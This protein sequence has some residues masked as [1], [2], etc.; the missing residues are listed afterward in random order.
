MPGLTICNPNRYSK[1]I[2]DLPASKSISNRLLIIKAL[3]PDNFTIEN[4]SVADDTVV[5]KQCIENIT[6][7]KEFNTGDGGTPFRFLTALFAITPGTRMLTGSERMMK[8]PVSVLVNALNELGANISYA[9]KTFRPPLII[10]GTKLTKHKITIAADVSSQ[11]ISALLLI[12]PHLPKGLLVK[13]MSPIASEPYINMTLKLMEQFGINYTREG[14]HIQI[15]RQA[16]CGRNYVVEADWSAA[17]FWYQIVALSRS[18]EV[19]LRGTMQDSLQGDVAVAPIFDKLGVKTSYL[20]NSTLLTKK[21]LS[22]V[23]VT[24]DFFTTPDLF[25]PVMATCVAMNLPFHFTGL[26]NLIVKESDRVFSMISEMA[27]FG[28]Y[29]DYNKAEGSLVYDGNPGTEAETPLVCDTH[30]DHRIAMA[31]A[32]FSLIS[33]GVSL[34]ETAC[35]S[36]SYPSYFTDLK[37]AGFLIC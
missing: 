2:I 22:A 11:F 17:A 28:Y 29:F 9:N 27:K 24:Y 3:C 14:K 37:K 33:K 16:Y 36:K 26:Q 15:S 30:Q 4:L 1:A 19:E 23:A 13:L 12:A 35:V 5:L 18:A 21:E 25:P 8:R 7:Q 32:P 6:R 10:K 20:G 31:L 34:N